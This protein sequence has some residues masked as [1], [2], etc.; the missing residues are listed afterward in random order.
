MIKRRAISYNPQVPR[1]SAPFFLGVSQRR[2]CIRKF[3][4]SLFKWFSD[5][6]KRGAGAGKML[7][8]GV[9]RRVRGAWATKRCRLGLAKSFCSQCE[10]VFIKE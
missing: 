3:V 4:G 1:F 7:H 6:G 2:R 5:P 10:M 9:Q 8:D